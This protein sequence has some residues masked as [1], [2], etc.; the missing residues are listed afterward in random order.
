MAILY[1]VSSLLMVVL[2]ICLVPVDIV[3]PVLHECI[4]CNDIK[5]LYFII[6][7]FLVMGSRFL[8]F[9]SNIGIVFHIFGQPNS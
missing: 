2:V 7:C 5:D 8:N 4:L 9:K 3:Y 1:R 6:S